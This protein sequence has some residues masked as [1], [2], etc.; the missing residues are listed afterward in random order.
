MLQMLWDV[1]RIPGY[2]VDICVRGR[3]GNTLVNFKQHSYSQKQPLEVFLKISLN[4][5]ENICFGFFFKKTVTGLRP[6]SIQ[7]K[8]KT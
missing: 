3:I 2:L 6:D 4:S 8:L 1:L 5:Q 7:I